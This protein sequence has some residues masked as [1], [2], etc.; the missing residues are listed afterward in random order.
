MRIKQKRMP[1][2]SFN[3]KKTWKDKIYLP[4]LGLLKQGTSPRELAW[5]TSLGMVLGVM[6]ALGI[7]TA[8]TVFVALRLRLN[9]ALV[10][11][12]TYLMSP[13]YLLLYVPFIKLG[14]WVFNSGFE[15]SLA[16]IRALFQEGWLEALREIGFANLMGL[17]AWLLVGAPLS[18]LLYLILLPVYQRLQK[19]QGRE[20][21]KAEEL[22]GEEGRPAK[23][24]M[25]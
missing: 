23:T 12:I 22:R 10:I 7:V 16:D 2:S 4:V 20:G 3:F 24:K 17:M 19:K 14:L 13:F 5:A 1:L 9:V 21:E 15:L 11:G 6:P 8:L 25:E 18:G